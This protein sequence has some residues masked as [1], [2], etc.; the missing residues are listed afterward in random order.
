[1]ESFRR[2]AG[3]ALRGLGCVIWG[4]FSLIATGINLLV[5]MEATGWGVF[6]VVLGIMFFPVTI[7]AAPWYAL[8]AWGNPIPLAVS[9]G[10]FILAMI[11][12]FIGNLLSGEE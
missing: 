4:L 8:L 7:I 11:L 5:I 2:G 1:M 3:G 12:G 9:Y 6:A 10:G